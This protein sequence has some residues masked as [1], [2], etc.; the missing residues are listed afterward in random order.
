MIALAPDLRQRR[1][2]NGRLGDI[3]HV[4]AVKLFKPRGKCVWLATELDVV[5]DTLVGVVDLGESE[6]GSIG[7][8]EIQSLRLSFGMGIERDIHLAGTL[9]ILALV[10]VAWRTGGIRA[11]GR[12]LFAALM[13]RR[14]DLAEGPQLH[15]ARVIG[16]LRVALSGF[17]DTMCDRLRAF[18]LLNKIIPCE[19]RMLV[20]TDAFGAAVLMTV[21]ERYHVERIAEREAA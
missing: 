5:G 4:P 9:S 7:L 14:A 13:P 20:P 6:P 2:A 11:A 1:P 15:R 17:T 18:E 3:D 10:E 12:V 16:T 21:L 8:R 19:L